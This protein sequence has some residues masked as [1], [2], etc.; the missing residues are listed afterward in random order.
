M[1]DDANTP[2]ERRPPALTRGEAVVRLAAIGAIVLAV[3][4]GFAYAGG[5]L[6]PARLTPV[7]L[8]D[9]FEQ[10]NGLHSGFRRNHAKGVCVAG[11][12][13][14]NGRGVRLSRAAVFVPG[15]V[16]VTGRFALAGGE[17]YAADAART[18]RSLALR[19]ALR[20]GEEWRTG[21]NNIP[22]FA[23]STPEGF[24]EQLAASGRDAAR[25]ARCGALSCR[26]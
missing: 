6:T 23:V 26:R 5:W 7:R 4:G 14:S 19:F 18:V 24:Y 9:T 10:V 16:P 1:P 20:D 3:T 2:G 17:P 13:E 8:V 11:F 25:A 15:R 12:F 21:M 22:V